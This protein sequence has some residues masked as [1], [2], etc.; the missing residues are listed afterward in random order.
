M[1]VMFEWAHTIPA[2]RVF[3]AIMAGCIVCLATENSDGTRDQ[4]LEARSYDEEK[5]VLEYLRDIAWS[6]RKAIRLYFRADCQPMKG[7]VVDYSV[8]FPLFRVQRPSP[9]KTGVAAVR[10]IFKNAENVTITE[11]P[12]GIIRI[13]IGKVPKEILRTRISL[14]RLDRQ[15]QYDPSFA[16]AAIMS[17]KEVEAAEDLLKVSES[18]NTG[19]LL[20]PAENNLPC[21]PALMKNTTVDEVLDMIAK[22]WG[23]PVVFGACT[24]PTDNIGRKL[25]S[26]DYGGGVFGTPF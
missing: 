10:E 8:P 5:A 2:F 9:D 26:I 13:W 22:T 12:R 16:I 7:S 1:P 15:A 11:Q 18:P 4:S 23:G 20:G 21:L 25:F 6:S 14:L 17:T 24:T 19:G 3:A